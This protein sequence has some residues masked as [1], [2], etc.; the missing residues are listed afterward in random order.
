MREFTSLIM[1]RLVDSSPSTN[2]MFL[3]DHFDFTP[4]VADDEGGASWKCDNTFVIDKPN[5]DAIRQ[6]KVPRNAIVTLRTS[7]R[8]SCEIGTADIPARV[9][10]VTHLQKAQLI[11]NCT[12]TTNPL[13]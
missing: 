6:F 4:T 1:V 2:F 13:A 8:R 3:S 7:D 9:H 10:I 12:M 11:V 5:D